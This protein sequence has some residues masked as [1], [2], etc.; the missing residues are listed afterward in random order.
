MPSIA[1]RTRQTILRVR[2][3]QSVPALSDEYPL[4]V[5]A[6]ERERGIAVGPAVLD[7]VAVPNVVTVRAERVSGSGRDEEHGGARGQHGGRAKD[8]ALHLLSFLASVHSKLHDP[9]C[10]RADGY[11]GHIRYSA[12]SRPRMG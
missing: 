2:P 5:L 11:A 9:C 12:R 1:L 4:S 7:V 10:S 3:G 8:P 6:L